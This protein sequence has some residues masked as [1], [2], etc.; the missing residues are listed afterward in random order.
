[1]LRHNPTPHSILLRLR[2]C[3]VKLTIMSSSS[4]IPNE[5]AHL[6]L[7]DTGMIL[8]RKVMVRRLMQAMG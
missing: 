6:E 1:M 8:R 2:L 7:Y 5:Q 4:E 3:L